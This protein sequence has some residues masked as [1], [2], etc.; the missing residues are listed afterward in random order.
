[1]APSHFTSGADVVSAP[2][3]RFF[4]TP[5]STRPAGAN[6]RSHRRRLAVAPAGYRSFGRDARTAVSTTSATTLGSSFWGCEAQSE[7]EW[8]LRGGASIRF[9]PNSRASIDQRPGPNIARAPAMVAARRH[10]RRPS[11]AVR[12][13]EIWRMAASVPA[14]GVH[15]P[16]VRRSPDP[17]RDAEVSVVWTEGALHSPG[18]ARRTRTAPTTRRMS[19]KPIPGQLPV[20][21]EYRRRKTHLA[22]IIRGG[23][24]NESPL[25]GR[26]RDSLGS[27]RRG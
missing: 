27:W 7:L 13:C 19:S 14:T 10:T 22:T 11:A 23:D 12:I 6:L 24:A 16:A 9:Q 3:P 18:L 5:A 21:V 26:A 17:A 1:M 15:S 8:L 2:R 20:N 4:R 25:T